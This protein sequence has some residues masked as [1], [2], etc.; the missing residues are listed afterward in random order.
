LRFEEVISQ[1]S[2][3]LPSVTSIFTG[4]HPRSHGV[5]GAKFARGTGANEEA[6]RL[7]ASDPS[8]LPD[9]VRTVAER[10]QAAGL[11]TIGVS[12]NPLV[13]RGTNLARGFETFVELGRGRG[14]ARPTA[15]EVNGL[16]LEWLQANA[17]RRFLGYLHYM[18][19]HGPYRPPKA[20]RPDEPPE[21]RDVVL[22][23][24]VDRVQQS[25][26][27]PAGRPLTDREL[28]HLLAL[29]DGVIRSWD[30]ELARL[31]RGLEA[32]G[33]ADS[34]IVVVTSDH[35][36]GF[37]EHGVLKH[38]VNLYDELIR[39]PLVFHG[40]G[41]T[42]RTVSAQAQGIDL[43]PT[44]AAI[45]GL[46]APVGLPGRNLLDGSAAPAAISETRWGFGPDGATTDLVSMRTG[47]WK[48]IH[49]PA[50]GEFELYDLAADPRERVNRIGTAAE[51][52]GLRGQLRRWEETAPA[53][54]PS[55]SMAGDPE[56]QE[57]LQ[58]LGYVD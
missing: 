58:A 19:V 57:K 43:V 25:M 7:Q 50:A 38:G 20:F 54:P 10:A 18:D 6:P 44:L 23:G 2:W 36:E 39:V 40:P 21:V 37:L 35:G 8:Y 24:Q 16:F 52:E 41:M 31:V 3:T 55:S 48:L 1:S 42:A 28:D 53:P 49:S 15:V 4:L 22:R 47:R 56:L 45:L 30:A 5:V 11:T 9:A 46:E 26:Q 12:T 13:S 14:T 27:G 17:G 34:T 32:A 51:A 29:Y 33:V